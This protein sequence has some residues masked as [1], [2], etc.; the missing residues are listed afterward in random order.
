MKVLML[1]IS[2]DT[3]TIHTG[4]REVWS[5]YMNSNPQIECYF[6]QYRDGP[7]AVE[8]NTIWLQ[9]VESFQ[10]IISKT[11]DCMDY[12]LT[13]QSYDFVVRT[14]LSSVWNFTVLLK[15]LETLPREKVYNGFIG[16]HNNVRFASGSGYIMTPDV[17][18]VLIENRQIAESFPEL[19]DV[20]VGYTLHKFNI[21]PWPCIRTDS[22]KYDE[23]AYHYRCK[24]TN[25]NREPEKD[26]MLRIVDSISSHI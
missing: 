1:I 5:R 17:C 24:L 6:M 22:L 3:E 23:D 20:A 12:F 7:Q 13:K 4:H 10:K 19:D 18:K 14:N 16:Y 21:N 25:G 2:S 9:G 15:Y 8:G 11:I 26:V